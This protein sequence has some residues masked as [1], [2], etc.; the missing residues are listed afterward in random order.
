MSN[1]IKHAKLA[2]IVAL[3]VGSVGTFAVPEMTLADSTTSTSAASASSSTDTTTNVLGDPATQQGT[4]TLSGK[5]AVIGQSVSLTAS[6]LPANQT[7]HLVWETF[8]G[9]WDLNGNSFI[10]E[11]YT[12]GVQTVASV[13]SDA[14]GNLKTSL[15][16]P[17]GYGDIHQ[18]G[19][20]NADGQVVAQGDITIKPT[21]TISK[22]TAADGQFLN[23][24][25]DGMGYGAYSSDYQVM[26]DN[27]LAGNISA[28][29]TNGTANFQVRAEGGGQ[30]HIDIVPA[31][32]GLPYL[33]EQ[34]SPYSWKPSFDF[35][36][37]V[38]KGKPTNVFDP[39]PSPSPSTGTNLVASP[40]HGVTGSTFTLSG[41]SLPPNT[42]LTIQW[43]NT[44]GNHVTSSG[45]HDAETVLG[46]VTTDKDG[47]FTKKLTV[48]VNVGGPPHTIQIVDGANNVLGTTNYQIYPS[49]VSA[50]KTVKAGSLFTVH[51]QGTGPTTYDNCY[52]VLYDNGTIGYACGF[53]TNGDVQIQVR[54]T[55]APGEHFLDIYP[56]IQQGNQK[57]P[58]VY[59]LPLLTYQKDH[60][61]EWQPAFHIAFT[62]TK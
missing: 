44:V 34:Q 3:A 33:N 30:H 53:N 45:Y 59:L 58:N 52:S 57:V 28:V 46:T 20:V 22:T 32:I 37:N 9:T 38:T 41:K 43:S 26:Y 62:I 39:I 60:P 29:T 36:V 61:G 56:T 54:A 51:L 31:S 40:G 50:P 27:K 35:P 17:A 6:G 55:G 42:A 18:I 14:A 1:L 15:K 48:P 16:I 7:F 25:V 49:F 4:L 23:I 5:Y 12:P 19:L 13:S 21:A 11:S 10:G 2:A 8:K 24:R 47:N